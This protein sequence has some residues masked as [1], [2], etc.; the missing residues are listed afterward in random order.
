[1]MGATYCPDWSKADVMNCSMYST[2]LDNALAEISIPAV[3]LGD[4]V[5]NDLSHT[6]IESYYNVVLSCITQSCAD[7]IPQRKCGTF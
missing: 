5:A 6:L 1:M 4:R 3:L 7:T 2:A